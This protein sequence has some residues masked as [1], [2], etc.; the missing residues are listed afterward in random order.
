MVTQVY[1]NIPF[2]CSQNVSVI[3]CILF[4]VFNFPLVDH[5]RD[6]NMGAITA[7]SWPTTRVPLLALSSDAFTDL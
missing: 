6:Q 7:T 2:S 5:R 1:G 4:Y 3:G